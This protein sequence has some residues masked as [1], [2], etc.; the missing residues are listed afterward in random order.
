METII[1]KLADVLRERKKASTDTSYA[2]SL[3]AAGLPKLEAKLNEELEELIE[4]GRQVQMARED[5][6]ERDALVHEAADLWFHSM[7]LLSHFDISPALVLKELERRFGTSGLDEKR[8][9]NK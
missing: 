3:M 8:T 2:A 7:V 1:E 4:A 6:E 9:R 5:A